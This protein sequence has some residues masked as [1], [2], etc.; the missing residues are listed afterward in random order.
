MDA[1]VEGIAT[2]EGSRT[3]QAAILTGPIR[4]STSPRRC[5]PAA[6]LGQYRY[7]NAP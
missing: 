2:H 7:A 1:A 6:V 3:P 4:T 5:A